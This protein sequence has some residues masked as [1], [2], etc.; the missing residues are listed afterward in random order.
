MRRRA[1][2]SLRRGPG[3]AARIFPPLALP[4]A[5]TLALTVLCGCGS[6][7]NAEPGTVTFLLG[8]APANLDPR[9]GTDASSERIDSLLYSGLLSHDEQMKPIPDLAV[10]WQI[11]DPKTYV[12]TL[13]SGVHFHDGRALTSADVKYT[14]DSILSGV[15]KTTKRGTYRTVESIEAPDD[16]TVI[17]HLRVPDAS[18]MWNLMRAGLGIVPRGS[19]ASIAQ[20]PNGTGPFRLE[21]IAADDEIVL[22]ANPNYFGERARIERVHFRIVPDSTTRA[23]ELRKGSADIALNSLTPDMTDALEKYSGVKVSRGP[24]SPVAYIAFNFDDPLI[25]HRELRQALAYATDRETIIRYLL[26]GQAWPA[27][28]LL[29]P[30]HWAADANA[31]QYPYEPRKSEAL[32]DAAGFHRGPD[33]TRV[34]LTLKTSTEESTRQ[35]AA[36][37]QDQ[38]KRVGIAL[39]IHPLEFATFYSDVV[40]GSFQMYTAQ[41][42]GGNNDP[43]MFEY[44]FSSKKFPPEGA[45]RGHYR[46]AQVDD[47]LERANAEPDQE[48]RRALYVQVQEIVG[49]DLPYIN[50]WYPDNVGVYRNRLSDVNPAP[51]GDYDFLTSVTLR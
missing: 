3:G 27:N 9:I 32:L 42:V 31:P 1:S 5:L 43:G 44:V 6:R 20:Q 35:L 19:P 39:D 17:F 33:G 36:A 40:H 14:L 51:S 34:H 38:W 12:F 7:T 30:N 22:A 13:R 16:S 45:N 48:K 28:S 4:V 46:N 24:G 23:L 47:L 25:A 50:L 41:W 29:P 11:P 26:R 8:T 49:Q 21:R 18:L 2:S 37:L 15:V 10:S